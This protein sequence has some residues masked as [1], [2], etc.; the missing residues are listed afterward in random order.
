MYGLDPTSE[1]GKKYQ[2]NIYRPYQAISNEG[3]KYEMSGILIVNAED[4]RILQS[5]AHT[6]VL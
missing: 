4:V 1:K 2:F 6:S 3:E 5:V